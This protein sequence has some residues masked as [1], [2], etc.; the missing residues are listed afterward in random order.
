MSVTAFEEATRREMNTMW[1]LHYNPSPSSRED[2]DDAMSLV[3][4][5]VSESVSENGKLR[6]SGT[7]GKWVSIKTRHGGTSTSITPVR[8]LDEMILLAA[9]I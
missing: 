2:E 4:D 7:R 5:L 1:H 9:G 6:Q 8:K 3:V